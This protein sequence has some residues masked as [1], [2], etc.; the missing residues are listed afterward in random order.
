MKVSNCMTHTAEIASPDQTLQ[1]VAQAMGRLDAGVM[2]LVAMIRRR[3]EASTCRRI[4]V[5][6]AFSTLHRKW[7]APIQALM[8]ANGCST[9][10][11]RIAMASPTIPC[12]RRAPPPPLH[13]SSA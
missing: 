3:L 13:V 4:S 9:V 8:V 12:V 1:E 7:V 2:P 5:L 11:R 10:S 6:T